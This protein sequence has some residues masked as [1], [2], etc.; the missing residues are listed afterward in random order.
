LPGH[1]RFSR[2]IPWAPGFALYT[3]AYRMRGARGILQPDS[4]G[5]LFCDLAHLNAVDQGGAASNGIHHVHRLRHLGE[6]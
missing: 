3:R 6:V 1:N 2:V 4:H 5:K